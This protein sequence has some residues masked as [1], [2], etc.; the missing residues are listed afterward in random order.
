M[1]YYLEE[2]ISKIFF[3]FLLRVVFT[4]LQGIEYFEVR[5]DI[6]HN[7][8]RS[9]F[10]LYSNKIHR[11]HVIIDSGFFYFMYTIFIDYHARKHVGFKRRV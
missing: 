10:F 5:F 4:L 3:L 11:I 2:K 6:S 1:H 9:I 8:F 7:A